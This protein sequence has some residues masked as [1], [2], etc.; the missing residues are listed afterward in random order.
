MLVE[1]QREHARFMANKIRVMGE[2]DARRAYADDGSKTAAAWMA[3]ATNCAPSE[4]RALARHGRRLPH[5]PFTR[6]ALQ[7]GAISERHAQILGRLHTSP[8]KPVT[9]AFAEAEEMLVGYATDLYFDDFLA[10]VRYWENLIDA[11]GAED[12][13][14]SD[15]AARRFHISEIWRGN[16]ALDGQLDPLSGEEVFT[17]LSRREQELFRHDW[18]EAKAIHGDNTCLDHLARTPA[19]RRADA[20]VEMARR[21]AAKPPDAVEPRPLLVVHLG[22]ETLN[23]MCELA[24]GTVITPGRLVPLLDR[25]DIQR[26]V[27][28]GRSR[29]ITDLSERARFFTGPLREAIL[30]RDRRC[31][32][33]GC[34]VPAHNCEVDHIKPRSKGGLTTQDNGQPECGHHNR[35]KSDTMPDDYDTSWDPPLHDTG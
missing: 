1:L 24:S 21:S 34:R 16:W 31:Q 25:A 32:H 8:R 33:P 26:I 18:D 3:R 20:L 5:M 15:H 35:F 7:A 14:A 17:E 12:Q 6:R 23:R 27:Y 28:A 30:L 4:A 10:A 13:A 19:Q 29:R 22:N 2:F 9:D 11:D